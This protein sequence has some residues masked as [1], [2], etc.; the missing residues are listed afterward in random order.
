MNVEYNQIQKDSLTAY[1]DAE[2]IVIVVENNLSF[3]LYTQKIADI[4]QKV[5]DAKAVSESPRLRGRH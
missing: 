3:A 2:G 5:K 1:R 4:I